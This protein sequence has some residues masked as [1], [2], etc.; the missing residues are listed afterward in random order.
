MK[1][2]ALLVFPM[3]LYA[4]L[5]S[6]AFGADNAFIRE[7]GSEYA[8]MA[9]YGTTFE[10]VG[11]SSRTRVQTFDVIGRYGYFLTD[12]L[13]GGWFKGRPQLLAELP[14]HLAVDPKVSPMVGVSVLGSWKFT[15]AKEFVPYLFFGAGV[16]YVDLEMKS[17]GSKA[18]FV[19]QGG[20]GIQYFLGKKTAVELEYRY[21]HISNAGLDRRNAP[22]NSGKVL[23]GVSF[24]R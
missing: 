21:H 24:F 15:A 1:K 7:A 22:I 18:N 8:L 2:Y 23:V 17:S 9:G 20:A 3:F 11:K 16:L 12:E 5:S 4:L 14:V 6:A 10:G 19:Y 13:G